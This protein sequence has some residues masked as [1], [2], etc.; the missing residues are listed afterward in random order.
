MKEEIIIRILDKAYDFLLPDQIQQLR[1][2]LDEEFYELDITK[3]CTALAL[4]N[5]MAGIIKLY[6]AAKKLEGLSQKTIKNYFL[7]LRDFSGVIYKDIDQIDSMDVRM[8]LAK[9]SKRGIKNSTLA[10]IMSTLRSFFAWLENEDYIEKSPMRKIKAIKVEKRFRKALTQEEL[11]MLRLAC[12]TPREKA[13]VEFF[14]STGCRLDEVYQLNKADIDWNTNS[15]LVIGKGNKE[16][17]VFINAKAKVHLWLYLDS[18]KD[19]NEALFVCDRR[20]HGRMGKRSLEVEFGK[21]GA[22]AGLMKKVHPH[23]LRHSMATA[24]LN[25]G[26][27]LMEVQRILGHDDPATT[28]IYTSLNSDDIQTAHRKHLA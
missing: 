2:I 16:R 23:I 3:A 26:A 28:L 24:L 13:M 22:K 18:R 11:E 21:L 5:N 14:Y 7:I 12:K 25:N 10:T 20:P 27:S 15:C 8:Y 9:C 6:L 1:T 19:N 17:K 4:T